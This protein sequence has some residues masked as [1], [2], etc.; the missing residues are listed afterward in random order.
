MPDRADRDIIL[1]IE[2]SVKRL[3]ARYG[4]R[5]MA[6]T[7]VRAIFDLRSGDSVS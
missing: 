6:R 4:D 2:Y 3:S 5:G 7:E 1:I